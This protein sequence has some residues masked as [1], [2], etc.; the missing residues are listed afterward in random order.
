MDP[1]YF[2]YGSTPCLP[3]LRHRVPGGRLVGPACLDGVEGLGDRMVGA[4]PGAP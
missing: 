4:G 1:L 2:A 3:R